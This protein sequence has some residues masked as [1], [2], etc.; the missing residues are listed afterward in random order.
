MDYRALGLRVGLEIHQQL[1]THKL[2]CKDAS[3]LVEPSGE[4]RFR[5]RL[6]PTQ[7]EL[8]EIDAAAIEESRRSLT[9]VYE[10]TDNTC[11]VEADEEPPHRPNAEALD[12]ALEIALLL[13]AS[14]VREV[15]F[16]RKIVID[17]SNTSG[18][19]RSA[20]VAMAGRLLV[21]G[22]E[23]G[24]PTILLEED[25]ARKVSES[26]GEVVYRLDRLGIPLVEVA[27]TPDIETPEEAREVALAIGSLLR[28]TR[29][30]IRGIGT[31]REDL[32]V[33]IRGGARVEVKGVQELR[34][35]STFVEKEVAR[36]V[37]LIEVA[38]ELRRRKV[39]S[40]PAEIVDL[41][42][43]FRST[44]SKVVA[45]AVK[46][47]GKV[48]G[49]RL[50][51]FAGL[52]R[53]KVGPEL[54]AHA[55]VA[56]VAGIFH[57][58]ELPAY[59][60]RPEEIEAVRR[61]LKLLDGDAFVLV[62]AEERKAK[63]AIELMR[64]RADAAVLGVPPETREPR[65]DGT[66]AYARPLPGRAR[67]YPETDVPPVRVAD[68]RIKGLVDHLPER[69]EV[70][71][72]RL[73][74]E[75]GIHEQQ[76]RQ[77]FEDGYADV[78][79]LIAKEFGEG[80]AA[81]TALTYTATEIR[82]E[83][84]DVD[85]IPEEHWRELFSLLRAGRFAK[86]AIPDVVR[87]MARRRVRASEAAAGLGVRGISR[88]ELRGIVDEVVL[89]SEALIRERGNAAEKAIMGRVMERVR[90]QADGKVVSEVVRERLAMPPPPGKQKR[91][92]K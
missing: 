75:H 14:P 71:I 2:F 66:T 6:R 91:K 46:K 89:A 38:D 54:A 70:A 20:L 61:T 37:A 68:S 9:F 44:E 49:W 36:Q 31:I 84:L 16:M 51:G 83:G 32:N 55:R 79:E 65:P 15:H 67:M 12:I 40:V 48:F 87:D 29:K 27:T 76:A 24:V 73:A 22:K 69:P 58:D 41:T 34:L 5:R 53:G 23:I 88:E 52:L 30:V 42:G 19:Q 50:P 90:G 33:S 3:R 59:G 62:A 43:A 81:A 28:A 18:F 13:G 17:G 25:A 21:G 86:E 8:G 64:R 7:S 4:R 82:R 63:D 85:G 60:I 74:A 35:I 80:R 92:K 72:P 57:S 10:A 1:A 77:L 47:G 11:L 26:E 56:G 45:G 39:T 78:F